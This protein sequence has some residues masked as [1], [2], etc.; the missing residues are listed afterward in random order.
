VDPAAGATRS[1]CQAPDTGKDVAMWLNAR[2]KRRRR[3]FFFSSVFARKHPIGK[4][5]CLA[6]HERAIPS[7]L[8]PT[9]RPPAIR[10][11]GPRPGIQVAD[12]DLPCFYLRP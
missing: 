3:Y 10:Q 2:T 7:L 4:V 8:N 12:P 1:L 9:T 6:F 5:E 11:P